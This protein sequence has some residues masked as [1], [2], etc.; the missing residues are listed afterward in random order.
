MAP[1]EAVPASPIN[2]SQAQSEMEVS[3]GSPWDRPGSDAQS[4]FQ[5]DLSPTVKDSPIVFSPV[6]G[7]GSEGGQAKGCAGRR[8]QL[9]F[10]GNGKADSEALSHQPTL[11]SEPKGGHSNVL[12]QDST[13]ASASKQS[14]GSVLDE[15]ELPTQRKQ[16][17]VDDSI[18]VKG[19]HVLYSNRQGQTL[20]GVVSSV[21]LSN[22]PP[23]YLIQLIGENERFVEVERARLIPSMDSEVVV[24]LASAMQ[25]AS[26][27]TSSG[28]K[29]RDASAA[30]G[31]G[32]AAEVPTRQRKKPEPLVLELARKLGYNVPPYMSLFDGIAQCKMPLHKRTILFT[33]RTEGELSRQ[34]SLNT[35]H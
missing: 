25:A 16:P 33:P 5:A 3:F 15:S 2:G 29:V 12:L 8:R 23:T 24:D 14:N 21:D 30:N 10:E 20:R 11:A 6:V 7:L 13:Q 18:L 28:Q 27:A 19:Q 9:R 22:S 32:G 31:E 17:L 35:Q 1:G 34:S 26:A 4:P